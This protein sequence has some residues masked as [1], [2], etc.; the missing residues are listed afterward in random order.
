MWIFIIYY[1][2]LISKFKILFCFLYKFF[3]LYEIILFLINHWFILISIWFHNIL[4]YFNIYFVLRS[5]SL[6]NLYFILFVFSNN[7]FILDIILILLLRYKYFLIFYFLGEELLLIFCYFFI[8]IQNFIN[9]DWFILADILL[10]I[11]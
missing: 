8:F 3:K 11:L 2:I 5:D 9:V 4:I 1:L 10:L 6:K 7:I